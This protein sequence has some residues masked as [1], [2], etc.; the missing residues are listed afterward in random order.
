MV[1]LGG[2]VKN[3]ISDQ[4]LFLLSQLVFDINRTVTLDGV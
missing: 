1:D 2:A 4:F 3:F